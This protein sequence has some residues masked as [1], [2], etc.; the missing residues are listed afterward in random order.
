[1]NKGS[2]LCGDITWEID[3]D[4][5]TMSNCHCSMCRKLHGT[6]FATYIG[7]TGE[8]FRFTSGEEKIQRYE[9]SPG[10]TRSSCPRCGSTVASPAR[11]GQLV[12]MPAGNMDGELNRTLDRHIFV[13]SKATWFE[14]TDAAP[15]HDIYPPQY[16]MQG[17]DNPTREPE[18]PGAVGGSCMCAA[19]AFEFDDNLGRMGNCHCSRCRRARSSA[20]STQLFV[21][22]GSFRWVSG[23]ENVCRFKLPGTEMFINSFCTNCASAMPT[24]FEDPGMVMVPAGALDQDP[25]IKPQAH[26]FVGSK[27]PWFQITDDLIQFEAMPDN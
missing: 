16:D 1:M 6:A 19:V 7:V 8:A 27:A 4:P 22:T 13:G 17:I 5:M 20:H 2:C 21:A 24:V 26:I 18:T 14:I 25:G 15:Q 3:G 9:S 23:E 11:D 10:E 12:F